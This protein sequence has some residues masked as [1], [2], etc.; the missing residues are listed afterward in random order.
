MTHIGHV[1]FNNFIVV[2][3]DI[4]IPASVKSIGKDAFNGISMKNKFGISI[5]TATGS[6]LASIDEMAL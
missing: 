2:T 4:T 3:S 5:T 1:A 6:Q